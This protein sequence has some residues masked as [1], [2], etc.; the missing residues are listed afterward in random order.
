MDELK[1]IE[2]ENEVYILNDEGDEIAYITFPKVKDNV[3]VIN[4]TFVDDSLRGLGIAGKMMDRVYSIIKQSGR[5][6]L[7]TCSYAIKYFE[8]NE[9]KQDILE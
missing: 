1:I 3:V 9:D 7:L 6:A 2:K 4:H 5:K 8:K